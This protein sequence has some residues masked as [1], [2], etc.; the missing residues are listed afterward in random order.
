VREGSSYSYVCS[1]AYVW[2]EDWFLVYVWDVVREL[3]G[4]CTLRGYLK[5]CKK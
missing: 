3:A 5:V 1:R 2:V 4:F